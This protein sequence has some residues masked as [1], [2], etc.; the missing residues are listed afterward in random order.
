M[1]SKG[2]LVDHLVIAAHDRVINSRGLALVNSLSM[3]HWLGIYRLGDDW[4]SLCE[5]NGLNW[6]IDSDRGFPS[7]SSSGVHRSWLRSLSNGSSLLNRFANFP[8]KRSLIW[9]DISNKWLLLS[10]VGGLSWL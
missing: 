8:C 9:L 10:C 5:L 6:L 1:E 3:S 2:D 4:L 7:Y